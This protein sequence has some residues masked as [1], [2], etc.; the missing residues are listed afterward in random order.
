MGL[1]TTHDCWHG[2]YSGFMVWRLKIAELAGIPL[3]LMDGFFD[4]S[5]HYSPPLDKIP[6]HMR[7][8]VPFL[9]IK[10][11]SLRPDP[12][13]F[14]L[15]HSD[16]EGHITWRRAEKIAKRLEE[17]ITGIDKNDPDTGWMYKATERFIKGAHEAYNAKENV[18]FH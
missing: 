8:L 18:E 5:E 7:R 16:C 6:P 12:I 2:S 13:H 9:P 4:W 17:L 3:P 11:E 14:L 1:D 10:W 15:D